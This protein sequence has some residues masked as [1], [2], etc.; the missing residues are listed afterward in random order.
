VTS[1][2]S[3]TT[4]HGPL[5]IVTGSSGGLGQAIGQ[6]FA[7]D[8]A[9]VVG[10]DLTSADGPFPTV[11]ADVA[12]AT[13]VDRAFA[14]IDGEYGSLDVLINN[15]G[16]REVASV[17]DLDPGQWDRVLAVNLSGTFYC[18]R[19]A[20]IRMTRQESGVIINLASVSGMTGITH[21]PAY[22]ASKHGVVGLTRNLA[23]DLGPHNIR[24]CA[25]AP[26]II[27]TP[28]TE[29]YFDDPAFIEDL[30]ASVPLGPAN[31]AQC[32]ADACLFLASPAASYLSGVVLPVDGGFTAGSN[33][34]RG[35]MSAAQDPSASSFR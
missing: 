20:A 18:A 2:T 35:H 28:L 19:Q 15:A 8:G 5:V 9:R 17:A 11:T 21:R 26:G 13:D 34:N 29:R 27:R 12:D 30:R 31:E 33:Y 25:V 22:T 24:V 7:A 6:A 32:V 10:I 4:D 14:D 3:N 16:I 23:M 1:A